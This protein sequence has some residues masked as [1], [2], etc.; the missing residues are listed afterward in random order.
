MGT[1]IKASNLPT[2]LGR[3]WIRNVYSVEWL[4]LK[5]VHNMRFMNRNS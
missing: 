3:S 1:N 5:R 4:E 2:N